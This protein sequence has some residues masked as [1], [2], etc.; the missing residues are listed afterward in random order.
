ML[1]RHLLAGAWSLSSPYLINQR[2]GYREREDLRPGVGIVIP[3]PGSFAAEER[4]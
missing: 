2:L 1:Q 3:E 4:D